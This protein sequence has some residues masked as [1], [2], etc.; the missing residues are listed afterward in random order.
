MST[1]ATNKNNKT[2]KINNARMVGG[3]R[4]SG[5]KVSTASYDEKVF[6]Q[7]ISQYKPQQMK[8]DIGRVLV[9]K[10]D[11]NQFILHGFERAFFIKFFENNYCIILTGD[12]KKNNFPAPAAD[13]ATPPQQTN[14]EKATDLK[15][16]NEEKANDDMQIAKDLIKS[17]KDLPER[18]RNHD[19][20]KMM[21]ELASKKL[22]KNLAENERIEIIMEKKDSMWY[23]SK[24][25][26]YVT[27]DKKSYMFFGELNMINKPS[28]K[29][30]KD[31]QNLLK[32]ESQL[33][34]MIGADATAAHHDH[35]NCNHD[36]C[37][38]DDVPELISP[39]QTTTTETTTSEPKTTTTDS[40]VTTTT[41][42][43]NGGLSETEIEMVITGA[44]SVMGEK[45]CN[46]EMAIKALKA[47][48]GDVVGAI[49]SMQD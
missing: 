28:E 21:K 5:K 15:V 41:T 46:R 30:Q 25:E 33:R 13:S 39:N 38:H 2:D 48:P 44:N 12:I 36:H 23:L 4:V 22:I 9:I 26:A 8:N 43:E 14:E 31:Q 20:R 35:S 16:A 40:L 37:H 34:D 47:H 49:L 1:S 32:Q 6:A 24:G 19:E 45:K 42:S 7:T 10:P 11:L 27:K 18:K 29:E 3:R 17:T